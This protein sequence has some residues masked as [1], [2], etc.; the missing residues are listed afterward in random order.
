MTPFS[1]EKNWPVLEP[2][3]LPKWLAVLKLQNYILET[4]CTILKLLQTTVPYLCETVV[5]NIYAI[6]SHS[7][8]V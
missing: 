3:C 5:E 8:K 6:H 4:I 1:Q 7:A 2:L